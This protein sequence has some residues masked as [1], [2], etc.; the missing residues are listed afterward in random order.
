MASFIASI[1]GMLSRSDA[2]N[3]SKKTEL[4]ENRVGRRTNGNGTQIPEVTANATASGTGAFTVLPVITAPDSEHVNWKDASVEIASRNKL[5]PDSIMKDNASIVAPTRK[6]KLPTRIEKGAKTSSKAKVDNRSQP[7]SRPPRS[8]RRK[9]RC[10]ICSKECGSLM[11]MATSKDVTPMVP[12]HFLYHLICI[13]CCPQ[14]GR[15]DIDLNEVLEKDCLE[16]LPTWRKYTFVFASRTEY[17]KHVGPS[18]AT[19][20]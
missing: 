3:T 4:E 13:Q 14:L 18:N 20:T 12:T 6:R 10:G 15:D 8:Q 19:I 7:P 1:L 5:I 16:L 9:V 2:S 11:W 17:E